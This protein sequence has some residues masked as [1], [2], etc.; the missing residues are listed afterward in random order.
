MKGRQA[1]SIWWSTT[2]K[3]GY[4]TACSANSNAPYLLRF[5]PTIGQRWKQPDL[6]CWRSTAVNG[7]G[8]RRSDADRILVSR[9]RGNGR[10]CG[11]PQSGARS[12]H[13]D[14]SRSHAC[15]FP[16]SDQRLSHRAGGNAATWDGLSLPRASP[17]SVHRSWPSILPAQQGGTRMSTSSWPMALTRTGRPNG[18]TASLLIATYRAAPWSLACSRPAPRQGA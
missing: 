11:S 18:S 12:G 10:K 1:L 4:S 8:V 16:L 17:S 3:S 13:A 14:A 5:P 15:C 6:T 2:P 7:Q 9:F